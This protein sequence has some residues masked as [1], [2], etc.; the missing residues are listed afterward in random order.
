[1]TL[2]VI[3]LGHG[4]L[5]K[6]G[7]QGGHKLAA[8]QGLVPSLRGSAHLCLQPYSS[9]HLKLGK[10]K[11]KRLLEIQLDFLFTVYYTSRQTKAKEEKLQ[12]DLLLLLLLLLLNGNS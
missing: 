11:K 5:P 6:L 4:G 10:I 2:T 12:L 3:W 1:M 7:L 9:V 8:S